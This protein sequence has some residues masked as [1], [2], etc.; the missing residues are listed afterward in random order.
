MSSLINREPEF[1]PAKPGLRTR[2]DFISPNE[3][4]EVKVYYGL[5]RVIGWVGGTA[6]YAAS[7][8]GFPPML[9]LDDHHGLRS[10]PILQSVNGA[11]ATQIAR[12][13]ETI[14][15]F[16]AYGPDAQP[17]Q[18]AKRVADIDQKYK[19]GDLRGL[20]ESLFY[21]LETKRPLT[22]IYDLMNE[23]GISEERLRAAV[24]FLFEQLTCR[25][26]TASESDDYLAI[27]SQAIDDLGKED[28]AMLGLTS[29]FLDRDA[30]FRPELAAGSQPDAH[31][32]TMLSG[33]ELAL[34]INAAFS[35][36]GPDEALKNALTEGRLETRDDV[37][38]EVEADPSRPERS[39]AARVAVLSRVFRL[40]PGRQ[41]L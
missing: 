6:A 32:R 15:R 20:A 41:C 38:R 37:R 39:Q 7:I 35:Y 23:P 5:D 30:L 3:E 2:G 29:I 31:G 9:S 1:D 36:L 18:F 22:P 33:W 34:A 25:P 10:Y 17:H 16:M 13:A 12:N 14:L 24:D 19:H 40:R 4:G 21:G 27:V 8:T 28:G 26:P 11:E